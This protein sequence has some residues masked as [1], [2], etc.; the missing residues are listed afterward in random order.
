MFINKKEL[1]ENTGKKR[2]GDGWHFSPIR[3]KVF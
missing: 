3:K 1:M 2:I